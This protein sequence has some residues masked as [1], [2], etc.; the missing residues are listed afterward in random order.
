M[1]LAGVLG[2][3][4]GP[5][6][7]RAEDDDAGLV[8]DPLGRPDRLVERGDVL[9]VTR[10]VVGPVDDLDVPAVGLVALRDI[11]GQRDVGVV[12]DRDLVLVVDQGEVA[13][14]LGAGEGRG[15][16]ADALLDVTVAGQ[17][18]DL[19]VEDR[20]AGSGVGIEQSA[21]APGGHRHPDSV[22]DAL[23]EGAGGGLHPGGVAVLRV[24]GRLA[25]PGAQ[26]LQ[27]LQ[28]QAPATEVELDVE[29]QA[30]V[31]AG[32]H[33]P[34]PTGPVGIGRVVPHHLLEQ[35]VRRGREAHG[36]AGVPVA[37]LLHGIH[38]QDANGVD[39][40]IVELGPVEAGICGHVRGVL[41]SASRFVFEPS[42]QWSCR[43]P[44]SVRSLG[45]SGD[46]LTG[47]CT[48]FP[49]DDPLLP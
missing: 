22:A 45:A 46:M 36:G 11:L 37:H 47:V 19:V 44:R 32:Q 12:L 21:L 40:S 27:V 6:D 10:A 38:G 34:V 1:G 30:A 39:C 3:R 23:A 35:Q 26:R 49:F 2:V 29:R 24:P 16:G 18:V 17:R 43:S 33:E 7:D 5:R 15:L 25:V 13:E 14:L 48:P 31:A 42:P 20:L 28:L 9:L 4:G 8:G 41:S